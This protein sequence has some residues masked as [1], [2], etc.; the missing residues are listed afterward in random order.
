MEV[1]VIG[2]WAP[3]EECAAYEIST[4]K[5]KEPQATNPSLKKNWAPDNETLAFDVRRFSFS[6]FHLCTS[7]AVSPIT[8]CRLFGGAGGDSQSAEPSSSLAPFELRLERS[9]IFW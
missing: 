1:L 4:E 6:L 7:S 8:G 3:S 5:N 2:R 9:L